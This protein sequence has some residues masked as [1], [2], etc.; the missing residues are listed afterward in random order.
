MVRERVLEQAECHGKRRKS[1]NNYLLP[2]WFNSL[3]GV[4]PKGYSGDSKDS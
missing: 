3:K 1:V 4:S 2:F